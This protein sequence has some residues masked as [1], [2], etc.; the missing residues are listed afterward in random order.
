MLQSQQISWHPT[1]QIPLVQPSKRVMPL[2]NR[3]Q[4]NPLRKNSPRKHLTDFFPTTP[5][6]QALERLKV[7]DQARTILMAVGEKSAAMAKKPASDTNLESHLCNDLSDLQINSIHW[8][9][10]RFWIL[11][12]CTILRPLEKICHCMLL[13]VATCHCIPPQQDLAPK[14]HDHLRVQSSSSSIN[15]AV[16]WVDIVLDSRHL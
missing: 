14:K 3:E 10:K 7:R 4:H 1:L 13:H 12:A 15:S 2:S 5:R 8:K 9:F 16:R 6:R 11:V